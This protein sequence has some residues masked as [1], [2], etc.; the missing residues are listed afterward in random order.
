VG[1]LAKFAEEFPK[2]EGYGQLFVVRICQLNINAPAFQ[3]TR[4]LAY[5]WALLRHNMKA[6]VFLMLLT[7]SLDGLLIRERSHKDLLRG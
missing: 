3:P 6:K 7:C 4:P 5:L 1:K 2:S